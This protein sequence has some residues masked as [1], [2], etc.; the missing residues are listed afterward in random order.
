M[1]RAWT[2][3]DVG[4]GERWGG[5]P[6]LWGEGQGG[7]CGPDFSITVQSRGRQ[8]SAMEGGRGL[9]TRALGHSQA[10]SSPDN[11]FHMTLSSP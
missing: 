6:Q 10:R 4:E 7:P 8:A 2:Q 1:A 9:R 5:A 3:G 11:D